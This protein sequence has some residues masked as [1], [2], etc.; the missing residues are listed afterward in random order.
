[1]SGGGFLELNGSPSMINSLGQGLIADAKQLAAGIENFKASVKAPNCFG[2]DKLGQQMAE[3]YPSGGDIDDNCSTQQS[4]S[5]IG[6]ALGHGLSQVLNMIEEVVDQG[7]K[8]VES[9]KRA[10]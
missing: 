1:M 2:D 10:T 6:E 9:T 7:E 5:D 4:C 3:C 8:N